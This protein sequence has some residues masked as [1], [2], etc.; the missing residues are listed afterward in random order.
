MEVYRLEK[1]KGKLVNYWEMNC[2]K[3]IAYKI[4]YQYLEENQNTGK[5][6][7]C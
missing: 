6:I 5:M 3:T 4:V 2:D 7:E 1:S